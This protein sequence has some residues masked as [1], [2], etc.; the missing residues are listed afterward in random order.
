[1]ARFRQNESIAAKRRADIY[2]TYDDGV[3]PAPAATDW[4]A[5]KAICPLIGTHHATIQVSA[6][7]GSGLGGAAGNAFTFATVADG[8]GIGSVT[9]TGS[10]YTFHYQTAVT[11]L[12][13]MASVLATD[14]TLNLVG[15]TYTGTDV[16]ASAGD[17]QG[18]L[19]FTGGFNPAFSVRG[20]GTT[21]AD[22]AGT[23]TNTTLLG[24]GVPGEWIYEATQ[25]E[26]NFVGSEF[27]IIVV[28]P[29]IAAIAI[30][31]GTHH[32]TVQ[33]SATGSAGNA[34][35]FAT[36]AD[37][38]GTGSLTSSGNAWTFHYATG[39]TTMANLATALAASGVLALV[40][41]S[42]TGSDVLAST[43]DTQGP[44]AFTGGFDG[45]KMT[46]TVCEMNDAA[47]F[48]TI[49]ENGHTYG[50]THRLQTAV[51][52]NVDSGYDTGTIPFKSMDA[53]KTRLTGTT[54][55]TGRLTSTVG[56]L[57]P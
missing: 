47:D 11:T 13:N 49:D 28:R 21:Y 8:T 40:A 48:D 2:V 32:A 54:A 22:A 33:A 4:T 5:Q 27:G 35:T 18:P 53:A 7:Y 15:G 46:I 12:A 36:A 56:D 38:S 25:S 34:L 23:F 1:M 43:G 31:T 42:F 26:L 45:F 55:A 44:I 37:G 19:P 57:T 30:L 10:A 16:L 51:L 9:H 20:G 29:S 17:T 14:G 39:T 24:S 6:A 3:T 41:G 50:D 52:A